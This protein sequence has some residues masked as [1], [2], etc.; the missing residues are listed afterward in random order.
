MIQA[1]KS[2]SALR[3]TFKT[4]EDA[5]TSSV[6]ERLFYLPKELLHQIVYNALFQ[7]IPNLDLT[8][9]ETV[10]FWPKW[11]AE[12]TGNARYVEPDVFIQ[13]R[14]Q[15]IIIEAKRYDKDQQSKGQWKNELIGFN[16]EY[17]DNQK[18]L[19]FIALGGL[20]SKRPETVNVNNLEITV[21]KC[22]WRGILQAVLS[23]K[24]QIEISGSL[25]S[26]TW[27]I[28]N[29]LEDIIVVFRMF[30]YSTAPWFED[31]IKPNYLESS[32]IEKLNFEIEWKK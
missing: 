30:G 9:I 25:L 5:L 12:Q 1:I 18:E 14:N 3:A 10:E 19:V 15:V 2:N 32:S 8:Q 16:N 13:T 31:F 26:S 7:E 27:A 4:N 23:A 29:I 6:F 22:S 28:T 17:I 20:R 24:N 11:N 21:H